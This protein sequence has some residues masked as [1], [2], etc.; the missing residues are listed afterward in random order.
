ML[1][2]CMLADAEAAGA[3]HFYQAE[4]VTSRGCG[5]SSR[6]TGTLKACE[7]GRR[8]ELEITIMVIERIGA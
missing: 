4:S 8:R 7:T 2:P 1:L 5:G 3:A 6:T